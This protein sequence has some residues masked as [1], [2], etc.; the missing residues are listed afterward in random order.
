[1]ALKFKSVIK[2]P[3]KSGLTFKNLLDEPLSGWDLKVKYFGFNDFI[4]QV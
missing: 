1:M 4:Y 2:N 3:H